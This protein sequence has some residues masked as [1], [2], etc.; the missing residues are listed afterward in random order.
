VSVNGNKAGWPEVELGDLL[1]RI[2]A[3]QNFKCDGRPPTEEEVGIVKVSAVTWGEYD[4]DE[5][6]TVTDG[7][8]V[9]PKLFVQR[10]DFLFSRA[11]T[12][13]LVGACVIAR[14]V[15]KR[16]MLSDKILR[17]HFRGV[18][19]AWVLYFL[20]S[21][22][23]R[24]QIE[25]LATGNQDSMR[26]IGQE[27][28]RSITLPLP[29]E[30]E[31]RVVL[32]EVEKQLTRIDAGV[33]A[34]RRIQANLK[35]YRA[36]VL[37]AACEGRLI[38]TEAELA[39]R[40]SRDYEPASVLLERILKER[41]H[42]WEA[43]ELARLK[44]KGKAPTDDRWKGKYREPEPADTEG[45]AEL[46]VGWCWASVGQLLGDIEAGASFKCDERPPEDGEIGVIKVS[47]VTWGE[48]DEL[49]SKTC[50][51][52]DR[53]DSSLFIRRGDFLFSRANTIELVGACVIAERVT[54]TIMLSD[55]I[56]R[57]DVPQNLKFWLL[58]V[59]RSTWGRSE[60]ERLATGN[61]ES[62]R[63]IGQ[64][65]LR[66][67]RLPLP[68]AAEVTRISAEIARLLSNAA[69]LELSVNSDLARSTRL[70]Q[71]LLAAAFEGKLAPPSS[72]A[73]AVEPAAPVVAKRHKGRAT[74]ELADV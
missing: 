29:P 12:I 36:T 59:L 35:R 19:P 43:S 10:G 63:N 2:E 38:P 47:G 52:P 21:L 4:E 65:R 6:K 54:R 56:L 48:Y 44:A 57:F 49:E 34:L 16:I 66:A 1:T 26:N 8:R 37:K 3:G 50:K 22:Q 14:Q 28:I 74:A 15:T 55:K 31:Q 53:V 13:Q 60:I 46:P 5:T 62:M 30:P 17:F 39:R 61:Q 69:A 7:Q 9:D 70:R 33:S 11:N 71:S 25:T 20:R 40:K 27:R 45:L 23:G 42:H 18:D 24:S 32:A 72:L 58:H 51:D 41:R 67:I 64:E 68:P 73:A